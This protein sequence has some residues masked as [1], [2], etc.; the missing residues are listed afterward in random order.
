MSRLIDADRL[1][2]HFAWWDG[3]D[4]L[5]EQ[6]RDF[7]TIIDLQPT[8]EAEPKHGRWIK[9]ESKRYWWWVCSECGEPP[10][11]TKF[12]REYLSEYCPHCG[13]PMDE[14]ENN[15]ETLEVW[16]LDGSPTR[17]IKARKDEAEK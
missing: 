10:S 3:F 16:D 5:K 12:G 2:K 1:K 8:V 17:Y 11:C 15:T 13:A 9:K 6:K 7:D 4:N 14:V